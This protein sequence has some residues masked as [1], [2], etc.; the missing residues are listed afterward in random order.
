M[1]VDG[2]V[3]RYVI[4][5]SAI[6]DLE[7]IS[8]STSYTSDKEERERIWGNLE[9]MIK[10][11]RL[12]CVS[13]AKTEFER[14]CAH[15]YKRLRPLWSTFFRRDSIPLYAEVQNVLAQ[16]SYWQRD[17]QRT[18]ANRDKADWYLVALARL[19]GRTVVTNEKH[20]RD[21]TPNNRNGDNIPDVCDRM[22]VRWK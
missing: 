16:S 14:R 8:P 10:A 17:A 19:E 5:T 22:G 18:K 1:T 21:R 15:A 9:D 6:G 12:V 3:K 11:D 2:L 13:A 4:D 7:G 20:R